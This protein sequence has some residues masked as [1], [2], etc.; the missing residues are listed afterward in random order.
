[1]TETVKWNYVYSRETTDEELAEIGCAFMWDGTIPEEDEEVLISDGKTVWTDTWVYYGQNEC[2]FDGGTDL[3]E[4]YWIS[5]PKP[6]KKEV[7]G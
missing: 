7:E 4:F 5:F 6:P 3:E 2:G 1:M